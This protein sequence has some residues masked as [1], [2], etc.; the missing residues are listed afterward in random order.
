MA[1]THHPLIHKVL[2]RLIPFCILCFLLNYIDRVNISIAKLKMTEAIPGFTSG[3]YATGAAVFFLGYFLFELPSNLIQQR[4]GPRRWIAR[5]MISWGIISICFMFVRGPWSFY[6]LRFLLGFAEAGFFP[7]VILYLSHWV[8]QQY[9]ARAS[10]LFLTSTA[11]SGVIGNPLGGSILYLTEK[12]PMW[13]QSWQWLFLL[14]GIPSVVLGV[15]T[16]MFL[17]DRPSDAAWLTPEERGELTELL[18][19]EH[20]EHPASHLSDLRHAFRSR[21]TWLLSCLYGL[22]VFGFYT[23]NFY[24]PTIVRNALAAAGTIN[25]QT[26]AYLVF[27]RVGMLSA[28]PFGAAAVAMVLI[29][30]SSDR[31][32]SHK[33]HLAFA[34]VLITVGLSIA[35]VT[36]WLVTGPVATI[37]VI[38]GMS[39]G[40]MGAFGMFGPFWALPPQLM[41]GT[42]LAGAFAIINSVGNLFGGFL[43]PKCLDYL[44]IQRGLLVAAGLALAAMVVALVLP[45]HARKRAAQGFEVILQK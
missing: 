8:P 19:R 37:L 35:A 11:I 41:T 39:I 42:A 29:A 7:G 43:G 40:A 26:P 18:A 2:W 31:H 28:I 32:N 3:V 30:R 20:A 34:C 14:E 6:L 16:L 44:D 23:V 12:Y 36:P 27:F 4:V 24:T 17:T 45:L 9:R 21:H 5:I 13:L 33:R 38:T 1:D 15:V 10:A 25:G 22:I